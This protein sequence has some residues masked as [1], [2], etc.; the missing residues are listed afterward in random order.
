MVG[1]GEDLPLPSN[2]FDV[3]TMDDVLEHVLDPVAVLEECYRVLR[4]GGVLS[5]SSHPITASMADRICTAI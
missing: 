5:P 2:S 4:P 1:K 3:V